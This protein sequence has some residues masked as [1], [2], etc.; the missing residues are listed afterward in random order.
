MVYVPGSRRVTLF[1]FASLSEITKASP[2][3]TSAVNVGSAAE[4]SPGRNKASAAATAQR[5]ARASSAR[6]YTIT[7]P[8]YE[9]SRDSD[10]AGAKLG[11]ELLSESRGDALPKRGRVLVRERALGRLEGHR[12]GDRLPPLAGLRAAVDVEDPHVAELRPGGCPGGLDELPCRDL[13]GD[14]ERQIL[15]QR[16]I[17]DDVFVHQRVRNLGDELVQVE[18]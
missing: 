4:D 17:G 18:L 8:L 11:A 7:L 5:A 6:R 16:G 9:R 1:P 10:L 3:P 2:A 15:A 13:L 14:D 12:E